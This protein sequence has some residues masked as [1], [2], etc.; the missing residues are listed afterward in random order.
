MGAVLLGILSV[1]V[2]WCEMTFGIYINSSVRL[3]VFA[4]ITYELHKYSNYVPMEVSGGRGGGGGGEGVGGREGGEGG[5]G[6]GG[7]GRGG[8]G[9]GGEGRGGDGMDG[10]MDGWMDVCMYVPPLLTNL[11]MQ[12]ISIGIVA[13]LS[14]CAYFTVFRIRIFNLYNLAP[15]HSTD[16]YSLLFSAMLLSRLALPICLN[17][18]YMIQVVELQQHDDNNTVTPKTMF[19]LVS[20]GNSFVFMRGSFR[21]LV[22]IL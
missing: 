2:V 20:V 7:E 5:E 1:A 12:A 14:V 18:L 10:W 8:E 9:R 19:A 15:H 22:I 17:Y 4:A 3:S 16:E 11:P 13:Y 6:R 21:G